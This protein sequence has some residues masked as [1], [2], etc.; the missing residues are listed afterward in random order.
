MQ[1][2]YFKRIFYTLS[3][4]LAIAVIYAMLALLKLRYF[5]QDSLLM[6]STGFAVAVVLIGGSRYFWSLFVSAMLVNLYCQNSLAFSIIV[7][8]GCVYTPLMTTIFLRK[9]AVYKQQTLTLES[10]T[11]FK[12]LVSAALSSLIVML[13]TSSLLIAS[14]YIDTQFILAFVL[15]GWMGDVLGI[16]VLMPLLLNSW[17][18]FTAP[19]VTHTT[20][21]ALEA[22]VALLT[23]FFAGLIIFFK[24]GHVY[25]ADLFIFS[26]AIIANFY[27]FYAI[28]AWCTLRLEKY[29]SNLIILLVTLMGAIATH[30]GNS[31]FELS[32]NSI[33]ILIT[34]LSAYVTYWLYLMGYATIGM[35]CSDVISEYKE[36]LQILKILNPQRA[37]SVTVTNKMFDTSRARMYAMIDDL[38]LAIWYKDKEGNIIATNKTLVNLLGFD[39]LTSILYK[40]NAQLFSKKL[41]T[42]FDADD[43]EIMINGQPKTTEL[44][45]NQGGQL[46][47]FQSTILPVYDSLGHVNGLV[48]Y[49]LNITELKQQELELRKAKEE[50]DQLSLLK[51]QFI[52]N[53]SHEIRTPMNG[54]IGLSTLALDCTDFSEIRQYVQ[55]INQSSLSLMAILN[56]VLDLSKIQEPGFSLDNRAF[57]L[58]DLIALLNALFTLTAQQTGVRFSIQCD[59]HVPVY[60]YG[61][62]LRLRQVLINLLGNAFKFTEQ[63]EV[64]LIIRCEQSIIDPVNKLRLKFSISDT[65]IGLSKEQMGLIFERFTQADSSATRR[66]GGTGLGLTISQGLVRAMGG[67]VQVQSTIGQG[68]VFSFE[69][70]FK[71]MDTPMP[72]IACV[73]NSKSSQVLQTKRVLVVEDDH[74]NQLVTGLML[75]KIGVDYDI[76]ENGE[77]AIGCIKNQV[78]DLVLMDIQMPVMDGLQA[79]QAIRQLEVYKSLPIIAMSAGVMLEEKQACTLAGMN[80]FVPKPIHIEQ[81]T[82]EM[83]R[84]LS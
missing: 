50:A 83:L 5:G 68:S 38:P 27:W 61:D 57:K 2:S 56:D 30:N 67:E 53:M 71:V 26:S 7:A 64:S 20:K 34:P 77:V 82:E 19:N 28:L 1:I 47:H 16:I 40:K 45:I 39:D 76:A 52:A 33:N 11:P 36:K 17:H 59:Q 78:Y 54:V 70:D 32:T 10:L 14:N 73:P 41:C 60:L 81:L 84:L 55:K 66:F 58:N 23:S 15:K 65:G 43:A 37:Q 24:V 63:G 51:T 35:F 21:H 48:G 46:K 29:Q 80:G 6:L 75:K 42:I 18:K 12:V 9:Y 25:I 31:Y 49:Q 79:T 62:E 22:S 13:F 44:S 74:I 3:I 69:L 8:L 4:H 72:V